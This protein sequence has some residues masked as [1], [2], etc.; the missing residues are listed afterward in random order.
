MANFNDRCNLKGKSALI[1]GATGA[2][3]SATAREL[4]AVG[5]RL[6]LTGGNARNLEELAG[7][8]KAQGAEVIS[9]HRRPETEEDAK[10]MVEAAVEAYGRLDLV[11]TASGQNI[12]APTV[13]MSTESFD[14]VMDAN[15]KGSWLVCQA[16]GR[17]MIAQGGGGSIV[18]VSSTR[19]KLG[20]PAGYSAYCASKAAV[21]LLGKTL[22]AE[23]GPHGIRVNVVGPTVFRSELTAWM[24]AD[25]E[26]GATTRK[27]MFSRI[28]MG[29]FAEAVDV[30]GP[31]L[32]LLSDAA[33]FCTGQVLY[34]D[35]GYTSC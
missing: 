6:T 25:D 20:H 8:L 35:G 11:L 18:L 9:V 1:T 28:P 14:K 23:W 12:V 32:F 22:A 27:N 24:F 3:G 21:D 2:L 17:Q 31:I 16:A 15:V 5:A 10:A 7:E 26:K 19:G 4:A 33:S 13:S 29:R 30:T 34:V